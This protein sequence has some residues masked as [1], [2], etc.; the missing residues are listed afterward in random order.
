VTD[1]PMCDSKK[2]GRISAA[3]PVELPGIEPAAKIELTC[4]NAEFDDAKQRETT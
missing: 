4:R 2:K 3:L 1:T